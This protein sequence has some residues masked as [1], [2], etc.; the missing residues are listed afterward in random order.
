MPPG[1]LVSAHSAIVA[2]PSILWMAECCAIRG[3]CEG[4][5]TSVEDYA[6]DIELV[7]CD[8]WKT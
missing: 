2:A 7:V 6:G 3:H 4:N 5:K 1:A 8:V